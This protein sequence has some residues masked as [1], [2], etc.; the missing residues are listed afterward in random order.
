MASDSELGR[1]AGGVMR[2]LVLTH[3]GSRSM[4]QTVVSQEESWESRTGSR[5]PL[6]C[7]AINP[8]T[9]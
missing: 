5:P 1:E 4:V 6:H 3:K 8:E 2:M 7:I 9:E